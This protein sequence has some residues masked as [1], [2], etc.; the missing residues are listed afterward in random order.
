V[1]GMGGDVTVEGHVR[2]AVTS[3][4]GDIY[5]KPTAKVD[6]D[7][8]VVGGQLHEEDGAQ[9]GGQRVTALGGGKGR[10]VRKFE[11]DDGGVTIDRD[12][13]DDGEDV[14]AA[15]ARLLVLLLIGWAMA[16]IFPGRTGAALDTLRREPAMSVGIGG[17]VWALI[18]P[19]VIAL[20]LVVALL[21]ITIIGI[22]LALAAL[23]G[24]AAF[25]V[26]FVLWGYVVGAGA[27]GR[28]V[29]AR[30]GVANPTLT[31]SVVTGVLVLA[32]AMVVAELLQLGRGP[33]GGFGTFIKVILIIT[34]VLVVTF[35]GGAWLRSEFQTGM[36]GRWWAGRRGM[37]GFGRAT[38]AP[39]VPGAAMAGAGA[40]GT[41]VSPPA[42]S[43]PAY[44]PSTYSPPP[45]A[46]APETPPAPG[47]APPNPYAPPDAGGTP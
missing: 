43:P 3:M 4:G 13:D 17:L 27:I 18:I 10:I 40:A 33:L 7:V 41:T 1:L 11:V 20:A 42:Y 32:G 29:A 26:V 6:G 35:G 5:L 8:V 34:E 21:C 16:R 36:L 39:T 30:Q 31:R 37:S 12:H 47:T 14:A 24:Y 19:S 44:N 38:P 2:G 25:L 45:P 28:A 46:P 15:L 22:P 23:L 9:V